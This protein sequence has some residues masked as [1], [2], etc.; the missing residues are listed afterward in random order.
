VP[1]GAAVTDWYLVWQ[2]HSLS[3]AMIMAGDSLA[4]SSDGSGRRPVSG[5]YRFKIQ[6]T[7]SEVRIHEISYAAR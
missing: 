2:L 5:V 6:R 4:A 3:A 1:Q 7:V